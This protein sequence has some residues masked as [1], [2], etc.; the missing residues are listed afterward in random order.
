MKKNNKGFTLAELLVV[1]A[2]IAV[3]VAIAIPV[4]G[5]ALEKSRDAVSVAN[6]RAAYAQ[7]QIAYLTG[8]GDTGVDYDDST[9]GTVVVTV[10]D[11]AI[12]SQKSDEWSSLS[13]ELPFTAPADAGKVDGG[14]VDMIFTYTVSTDAFTVAFDS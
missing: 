3:L 14:K 9:D 12:K 1:V 5:S 13:G 11:V 4:F 10:S 2:I 7:A 8:T 6:M